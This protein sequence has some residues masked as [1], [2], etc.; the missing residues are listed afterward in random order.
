MRRR[1]KKRVKGWK[2]KSRRTKRLL[3]KRVLVVDDDLI[4]VE[5]SQQIL[6][7]LGVNVVT[8]M[9]GELALALC[10]SN[11]F[12]AILLDCHLPGITGYDIAET[13]THKEGCYTP[14]I[15]LSADETNEASEKRYLP[16]CVIT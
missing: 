1:T 4:S 13:L 11:T 16:A 9:T 2:V 6:K 12:D 3:N 15:A 14:I 5:I 10:K 7:D 8:A